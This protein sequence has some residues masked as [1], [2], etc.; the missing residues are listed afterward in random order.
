MK[1]WFHFLGVSNSTCYRYT[2]GK[3]TRNNK[4]TDVFRV[5]RRPTGK[6]K[7]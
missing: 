7:K 1:T 5:A 4:K 3:R 6:K 2:K